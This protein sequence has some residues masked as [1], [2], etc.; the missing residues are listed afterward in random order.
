[1]ARPAKSV[2]VNSK[3]LT[4]EEI[5]IRQ[6]TENKLKGSTSTEIKPPAYLSAKQKRIF[7]GIVSMLREADILGQLDTYLLEMTAI[8]IDRMREYEAIINKG[9]E[10]TTFQLKLLK[11][12]RSTFFRCCNEL[13]LSPQSRAKM[14]TIAVNNAEKEADPVLKIF[15][16]G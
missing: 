15:K 8:A 16:Q 14:G 1:M 5:Q 7:R 6:Q 4:K 9:E 12:S 3:N 11:D 2:N 10:L 13:S